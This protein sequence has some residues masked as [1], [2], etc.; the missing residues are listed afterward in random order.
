MRRSI[1]GYAQSPFNHA[2]SI[3]LKDLSFCGNDN[4]TYQI[5]MNGAYAHNYGHQICLQFGLSVCHIPNALSMF[6]GLFTFKSQISGLTFGN[7]VGII[8]EKKT[9]HKICVGFLLRADRG[10]HVNE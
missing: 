10:L 4:Y 6:V 1:Y 8:R 2:N 7:N 9:T 3:G 5:R